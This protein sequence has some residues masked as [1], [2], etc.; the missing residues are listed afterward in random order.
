MGT[1]EEP[2]SLP[3]AAPRRRITGRAIGWILLMMVIA[4]TIAAG[5]SWPDSTTVLN[6]YL[7]RDNY[8]QLEL[9]LERYATDQPHWGYP[10]SIE[11]L[12]TAGY[13]TGV[14]QNPWTHQPM[15][16]VLVQDTPT[17]GDY[18][19]QAFLL[20]HRGRREVWLLVV[21]GDKSSRPQSS[22][23]YEAYWLD[24]AKEGEQF[25]ISRNGANYDRIVMQSGCDRRPD[26]GEH[27][28]A[29]GGVWRY[30]IIARSIARMRLKAMELLPDYQGNPPASP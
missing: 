14:P 5:I 23:T 13:L 21:Y 8:S 15:D 6:L 27:C 11:E 4:I 9:A 2:A 19:Y 22:I 17:P 20:D 1:G 12:V 10:E 25:V 24:E 26:W 18:C 29:L 30:S 28:W 16:E 3:A 7:S